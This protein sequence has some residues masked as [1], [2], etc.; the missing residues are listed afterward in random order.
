MAKKKKKKQKQ[1][2]KKTESDIIKKFGIGAIYRIGSRKSLDIP[3]LPT[4]IFSLDRAIGV[5]GY[6]KGRIIEL[7]GP[8]SSGKT[9]VALASIASCQSDGGNAV[10]IDAEH[11]L[12]ITYAKRIGVDL[13]NLLINQ[14]DSGEQA[15]DIV[16]S[17]ILSGEIDIVV[18]DSVPALVP[19]AELKGEMDKQN[20][21]RQAA[22]MSKA[23]QR[24]IPIIGKGKTVLVFIN[25]VRDKIGGFFSGETTPGGRALK[26]ACTARIRLRFK[27]NDKSKGGN[28]F[29]GTIV[30]NKVAAPYEKFSFY[31]DTNFRK[32]KGVITWLDQIQSAIDAD[33]ISKRGSTL[34]YR[35]KKYKGFKSFRKQVLKNEKKA[36]AFSRSLQKALKENV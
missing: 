1:S 7:Y 21:G 36:K 10:F 3:S 4:G 26:H 24:I 6:P 34:T 30:K 23:L 20:V 13:D 14:P 18:V 25:Q 22:M 35:K 33:V 16:E 9:T 28:L 32:S 12:D 29:V 5:G 31:V 15:L 27:E 8:E 2:L 11:A 19:E 17:L